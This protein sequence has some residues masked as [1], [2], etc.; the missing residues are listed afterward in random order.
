MY[1][2]IKDKNFSRDFE[3]VI[4]SGLPFSE[5]KIILM[6]SLAKSQISRASWNGDPHA[7]R[8]GL[9][10][11]FLLSTIL[12]VVLVAEDNSEL[13]FHSLIN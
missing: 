1:V 5:A 10:V 12:V 11:A 13:S 8:T 2:E 6:N 9:M 3:Q 7:L 4:N